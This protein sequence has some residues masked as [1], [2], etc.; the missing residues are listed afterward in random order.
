MKFASIL[1]ALIQAYHIDKKDLADHLDTDE[2]TID[3]WLSG[4]DIPTHH[5]LKHLSDMYI[6]PMKLLEDSIK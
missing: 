4:D 3:S 1:E 5:Q 6:L 2:K